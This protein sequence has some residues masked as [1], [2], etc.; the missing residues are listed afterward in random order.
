MFLTYV[1]AAFLIKEVELTPRIQKSSSLVDA[2]GLSIF[3]IV[4]AIFITVIYFRCILAG[5]WRVGAFLMLILIVVN[6][7]ACAFAVWLMLNKIK[8]TDVDNIDIQ[9]S[10]TRRRFGEVLTKPGYY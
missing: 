1:A 5:K 2:F 8:E 4:E 10:S 9:H 6:F 7:L 3:I